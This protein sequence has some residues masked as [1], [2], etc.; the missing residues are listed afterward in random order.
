[1]NHT[2]LLKSA[3][4]IAVIPVCLH[5]PNKP[6]SV[7]ASF[8]HQGLSATRTVLLIMPHFHKLSITLPMYCPL[9]PASPSLELYLCWSTNQQAKRIRKSWHSHCKLALMVAVTWVTLLHLTRIFQTTAYHVNPF[10]FSFPSIPPGYHLK[11]SWGTS[12]NLRSVTSHLI[13]WK[14]I[15]SRPG[16]CQSV[17]GAGW[18][19]AQLEGA[20][21]IQVSNGS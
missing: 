7:I 14:P 5:I 3:N 17:K 4:T 1:M 13:L 8:S 15:N 16:L 12:Q 19:A 21:I 9:S 18:E 6:F 11:I 20:A 2:A 10:G